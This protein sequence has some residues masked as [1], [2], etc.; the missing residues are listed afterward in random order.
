MA[1]HI[2]MP[3]LGLTMTEGTI[4]KWLVEEGDSISVGDHIFEV[5]TDKLT[6]SIEASE[7]GILRKIL[8]EEGETVDCLVPVGIIGE[9][10]ENIDH[11][12]ERTQ[13][14]SAEETTEEK[15]VEIDEKIDNLNIDTNSAG[16][17]VDFLVM[18]KLGLTMT[19]GTI[20]K[21]L[22]SEGDEI[23]QGDNIFQVE[24]DKLTNEVEASLSG[25]L[26]KILVEEGETV[27]C[28]TP[29]GILA[30]EN[31]DIS[32]LNI[33]ANVPEEIEKEEVEI[34]EEVEEREIINTGKRII[35]TPAA[36]AL[37]NRSR[38]DLRRIKG[39]G[40]NGRITLED[41]E[42]YDGPPR[43]LKEGERLIATPAAKALAKEKGISLEN[44][45]G[46]G[47]EGRLVLKDVENY[48]KVLETN[49][50]K[51]V[52]S[53][54]LARKKAK[55]AGIDLGKVDSVGRIRSEDVEELIGEESLPREEVVPMTGMRKTIARRMVESEEISAKVNFDISVDMTEIIKLREELKALNKKVSF[56]DIIVKMTSI[57]LLEFP[58]LNCRVDGDNIIYHNYVNMGV[59][60]AVEDGLLVP[61]VKN[62]HKK[63]LED[64][65]YEIKSL[66]RDAR[67]NTLDMDSLQGA[68]FTI[69][70]LGMYGIES[71]TPIINQPEVAILGVNAMEEKPV[72]VDGEITIKPMMKFSLSADHRIIDGAVAAEFLREFKRFMENP[73]L[74][75][76]L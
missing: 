22:V 42:K 48:I 74:L 11:L 20:V 75:L 49:K 36:K 52:S 14:E 59:A 56:T 35:A 53:T 15:V 58:N 57:I 47:P 23:K 44:I 45:L 4:V 62:S 32:N 13:G 38:A 2:V 73:S 5:E 12:L 76:T 10:D 1:N 16:E 61:V 31:V 29:V 28:F 25:T 26:R 43:P 70:N 34:K 69:T 40:P 63:K 37:A 18:P 50:E 67:N 30:D 24:T 72:V 51:E 8:V 39:T 17:D 21:W 9:A 7:S 64:I 41:V 68:T 46:T 19:E 60:V 55:E 71:F 27:D 65:S 66:A 54:P 6:N 33:D 3:K